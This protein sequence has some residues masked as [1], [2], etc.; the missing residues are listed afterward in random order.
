M[1]GTLKDNQAAMRARRATAKSKKKKT[2]VVGHLPSAKT[3]PRKRRVPT[4]A[5]LVQLALAGN[6]YGF[7]PLPHKLQPKV[8]KVKKVHV[9]RETHGTRWSKLGMVNADHHSMTY[10]SIRNWGM[11]IKLREDHS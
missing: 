3:I 4:C 7:K 2:L 9:K 8:A 11:K 10:N 1:L 6:P 5:E